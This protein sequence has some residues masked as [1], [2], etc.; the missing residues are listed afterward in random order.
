MIRRMT[1]VSWYK[2]CQ[3]GQADNWYFITAFR[4]NVNSG[5]QILPLSETAATYSSGINKGTEA[6]QQ[7]QREHQGQ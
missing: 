2:S 1:V 7:Q 4:S 5:R 6:A 3:P